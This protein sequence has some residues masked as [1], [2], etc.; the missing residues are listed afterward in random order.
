M[1]TYIH[2]HT[3]HV[4]Q[5]VSRHATQALAN[6]DIAVWTSGGAEYMRQVIEN[7]F[8]RRGESLVFAWSHGRITRRYDPFLYT[9]YDVKDLRKIRPL[10]YT[11][12]RTLIVDDTR[13]KAERNY[14]NLVA[15]RPFEGCLRGADGKEE[16]EEEARDDELLVLAKYLGVVS[17]CSNYRAIEKR[18]WRSSVIG[19]HP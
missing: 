5:R 18:D 7:I 10:G 12:E 16:E 8:P 13:R 3:H 19:Q 14:G 17:S 6:Y 15:V 1:H 4:N 11:L 2:A 9:H